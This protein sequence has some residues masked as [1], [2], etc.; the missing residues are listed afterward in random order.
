MEWSLYLQ[1]PIGFANT[2]SC[3]K[4]LFLVS[5]S[6]P[7]TNA[8]KISEASSRAHFFDGSDNDT[9]QYQQKQHHPKQQQQ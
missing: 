7:Q 3:A 2:N 1:E 5:V 8:E 4:Q 6:D 9:K